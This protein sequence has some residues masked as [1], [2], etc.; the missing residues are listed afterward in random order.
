M[1]RGL[2]RSAAR[3][4]FP[5]QGSSPVSPALAGGFFTTDA[6]G[7]PCPLVLMTAFVPSHGVHSAL[8]QLDSHAVTASLLL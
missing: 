6:A 1:V 8:S 2:S 4:V 7:R 5:G 3:G